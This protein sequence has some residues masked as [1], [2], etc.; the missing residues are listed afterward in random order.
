MFFNVGNEN[1][2]G[3][4]DKNSTTPIPGNSLSG[5]TNVISVGVPQ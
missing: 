1:T 2:N 3:T 5:N 4:E